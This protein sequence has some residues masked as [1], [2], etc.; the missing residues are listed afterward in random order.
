M[1]LQKL[2]KTNFKHSSYLLCSYKQVV[3]PQIYTIGWASVA[4]VSHT[5]R[6]Q[7]YLLPLVVPKLHTSHLIAQFLFPLSFLEVLSRLS[8][9]HSCSVQTLNCSVLVLVELSTLS[10]ALLSHHFCSFLA[11][12]SEILMGL[13]GSRG[14]QTYWNN[15]HKDGF[16]PMI[17]GP[18]QRHLSSQSDVFV[19]TVSLCNLQIIACKCL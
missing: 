14:S 17:R 2:F 3:L 13:L 11:L 19:H 7:F 12:D 9:K 10:K 6:L 18:S 15:A 8:K 5:N 16:V 1:P 4:L